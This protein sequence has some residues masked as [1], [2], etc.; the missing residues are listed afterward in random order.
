MARLR[1]HDA[2]MYFSK[3]L[4]AAEARGGKIYIYKVVVKDGSGVMGCVREE[5]QE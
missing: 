3:G 4:R 1:N 2:I 5:A